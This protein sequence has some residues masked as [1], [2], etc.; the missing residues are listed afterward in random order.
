MNGIAAYQEN[1]VTT[2][3]RG[4]LIVMLYDGAIKF[5]RKA[6]E[7]IEQGDDGEKGRMVV[8]AM[9]IVDELDSSLNMEAGGEVAANLRALYDFMRRH[10]FEANVQRDPRKIEQVIALLDELNEGW[11]AITS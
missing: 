8:K 11:R 9:A 2:Q 1:T 4:R 5:L 3:S 10:L 6:L 7:A